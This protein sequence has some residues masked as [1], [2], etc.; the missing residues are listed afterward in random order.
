MLV[1]IQREFTSFNIANPL[2]VADA[3]QRRLQPRLRGLDPERLLLLHP[4]RARGGGHG[5]R[6][7]PARRAVPD[8]P[9]AGDARH[10]HRAD[11][12]LHRRVE[13]A[14]RRADVHPGPAQRAAAA[15]RQSQQL[16]RPVLD[17]LGPRVRRF[18]DR[19]AAGH[20]AVRADRGQGRRRAHRRARSS[21][22]AADVVRRRRDRQ[23]AELWWRAA[24]TGSRPAGRGR[25]A[26]ARR[27]GGHGRL[28]HVAV[29]GA[30]VGRAARAAGTARPM[31]SPRRSSRPPAA[32]TTSW[33]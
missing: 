4:G 17:R 31:R 2:I 1:G 27:A 21:S 12:H 9:A 23:P 24:A 18:G 15:D 33:R 3:G 22:G 14:A 25:P 6:H 26:G 8:H 32:T 28:R 20:R 29:H 16:H 7:E 19:D 30:G 10:R 11:L 13:R 5:R